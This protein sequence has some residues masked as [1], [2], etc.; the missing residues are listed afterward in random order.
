M[1]INQVKVSEKEREAILSGE[2]TS[3]LIKA[4]QLTPSVEYDLRGREL[5]ERRYF[6]DN[7][8]LGWVKSKTKFPFFLPQPLTVI[9]R[10]NDKWCTADESE[11]T[12][13]IP[14]GHLKIIR[15]RDVTD[16][17]TYPLTKSEFLEETTFRYGVKSVDQR[18]F[19]QVSWIEPTLRMN[20]STVVRKAKTATDRIIRLDS[21]IDK[22][23]KKR[24]ALSD[25]RH[26]L[27]VEVGQDF[28][29]S[30]PNQ[31]SV[32]YRNYTLSSRGVS[33]DYSKK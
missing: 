2:K 21:Q 7:P 29:I 32:E 6:S 11:L 16:K 30:R 27:S 13:F 20:E 9:Y 23:D 19:W 5:S 28:T 31:A 18:Y 12:L 3:L 1:T 14:Y 8:L 25:E 33:R 4:E 26:K 24:R 17:D 10:V 15:W 22:L